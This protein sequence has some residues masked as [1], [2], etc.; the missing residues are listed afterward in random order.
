[1]KILIVS[2][3]PT[4]PTNAGNRWGILAQAEILMKLGN[5]VHFLYIKEMPLKKDPAPF[6]RDY[7]ETKAYWGKRFHCFEVSKIAKIKESLWEKFDNI[8]RNGYYTID[9]PYPNG[10]TS[11]AKELQTKERFDICI[12]NYIYLTKLFTKVGFP[13]TAIFTHDCLS[14]KD[15]MVGEKCRTMNAHQEATG[16]QRCQHIFAVQDEEMAYFH[17]LSPRSK[18]Y[19]IYSKYDY[20]PQ[21]VAGNQNI[22]FLSGGNQYNVN[23]IRW[24]VDKVFPH[25]VHR[26][27]DAQLIIGG[28]IC[29]V[30]KNVEG[31][32]GVTLFGYVDDPADFYAQAD[33]AIN[34][35]YQGTGLKIKTFEAISYD[36]VTIVHPHSMAGVFHKDQAPLLA[37]DKPEDWVKYL[38]QIWEKP[39]YIESVKE[40]NKKYLDKMNE[41]VVNEYKRFLNG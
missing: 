7:E 16:L 30:L 35:V 41:F 40:Y 25:I 36:K 29:K 28:S 18:V 1:M 33:V 4:H 24:F 23:G 26:F 11:Y 3:C 6:R 20:H 37:S 5:K 8:F 9:E 38:K 13:K 17:L 10:L 19:N 31:M 14:Y 32:K 2:K 34:P 27:P 22:V 39:R 12:I 15:L 21:K